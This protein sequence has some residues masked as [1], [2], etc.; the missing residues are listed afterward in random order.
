MDDLDSSRSV[1]EAG[2]IADEPTDEQIKDTA[3]TADG[4]EISGFMIRWKT[5]QTAYLVA[6]SDSYANLE[7][8][9]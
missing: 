6:D 4:D 1:A 5:S 3:L 7:D 2:E 8:R 9:T